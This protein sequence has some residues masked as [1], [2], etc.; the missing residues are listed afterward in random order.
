MRSY[1]E[2]WYFKHQKG[3]HTFAVIPGFHIC[4]TGERQAFIQ[5]ITN[6]Q[7]HYIS[8]DYTQYHCEKHGN[9]CPVIKIAD[10]LFSPYGMKL[11][12]SQ[13]ELSIQGQI[14]YG[15]LTPIAYDIM[16][17]FQYLPFLEC[18]HGI[19]SMGHSLSGSLQWGNRVIDLENGT[20]YIE[21]DRG[22]SFPKGYLWTQCNQFPHSNI[23]LFMAGAEIPFAGFRFHGCIAIVHYQQKEYRFATY[24]GARVLLRS[25]R[26][27]ILEQGKYRLEAFLLQENPYKLMAPTAGEMIRTIHEH[28]AC[29]V[30]YRFSIAQHIIFDCISDSASF[31]Y[32]D[33]AKETSAPL[34]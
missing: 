7:S 18:R 1:F 10:N 16:G 23:S 8:Y 34:Q 14:S 32:D 33:P 21:T 17:P 31:E 19:L 29:T 15:A 22:R 20:G 30:Q 5:V 24:L 9:Q 6:T 13:E 26:Q 27:I 11:N 12:I 4:K 3:G 25:S 2:G 28:A